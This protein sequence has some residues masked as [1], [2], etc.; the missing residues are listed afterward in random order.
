MMSTG[1]GA[2]FLQELNGEQPFCERMIGVADG[3]Q[4]QESQSFQSGWLNSI[5]ARAY[6]Q[7][8]YFW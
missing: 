1:I 3:C 6:F 4:I 8:P 7:I 2:S 5:L